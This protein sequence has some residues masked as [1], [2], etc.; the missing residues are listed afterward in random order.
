MNLLS[1]KTQA[2][3]AKLAS[4]LAAASMTVAS[5]SSLAAV[6]CFTTAIPVPVTT[7][8]IYINLFTGAAGTAAATTGWDLNPWGSTNLFI[9]G[10][11]V[12]GTAAA[13]V[14]GPGTT[15]STLANGTVIGPASTFSA[16]GQPPAA[17]NSLYRAGVTPSTYLG[18]RFQEGGSTYYG[19]VT[20]TTTAT[21]GLPATVNAWCFENTPNTAIVAGT[22][23]VTLQQ[24][25]VD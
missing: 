6:A 11:N 13:F 16:T 24:F 10:N 4:L 9:W 2:R 17:D 18:V 14:T 23:P 21:T 15:I 19:W 25:S 22:T 7:A 5:A 8:G 20:L 1:R 12:A 3:G